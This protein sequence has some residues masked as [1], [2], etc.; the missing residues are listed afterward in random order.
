M[1]TPGCTHIS[2]QNQTSQIRELTS[3]INFLEAKLS[4]LQ[5]H[6]EHCDTWIAGPPPAGV[7][8]PYLP[9]DI[10]VA[11]DE[12]DNECNGSHIRQAMTVTTTRVSQK[13]LEGKPRWKQIVDQMTKGWDNPSS[14]SEKRVDV[15]LDSVEQNKF[16][17]TAIL[18]LKKDLPLHLA[19][20]GSS[21]TVSGDSIGDATNILVTSARQYALDSKA[22]E[23]KPGLVAQVHVFRELVF[24][25]LC[26]V[27]EH[28]GLPIETIDSLMRICISNSGAANLYRLR[29][30]ALWVNRVISGTMI[31]K[32]GWGHSS[33]E[34]FVLAGRPVS[35]YGLLWEACVHSFPYFRDQL[36][37]ISRIVETPVVEPDWIPFSIPLIIK[38]L[39][40]NALS[41]EQICLALDYSIDMV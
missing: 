13:R 15:G 19:R 12:A 27:M 32:L 7:N 11:S 6:H 24:I 16:A 14:W 8:L 34:F 31:R 38:Q 4:Y 40:G 21:T 25:S 29:R 1:T 35:Q 36:V 2:W 17:L 3:Y 28:E 23:R 30:G 41:L 5:R 9:P 10:V 20:D 18:G 26:V 33:T 39:V 22:R 37:H